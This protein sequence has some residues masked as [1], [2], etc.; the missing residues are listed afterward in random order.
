MA[1]FENILGN[2]LIKQSMAASVALNRVSHAYII[3][4]AAGSGKKLLAYSFA[5]AILCKNKFPSLEGRTPKAEVVCG[6]CRS[7]KTADSGNNPDLVFIA[8]QKA[9]LGIDEVRESIIENLAV[10]PYEADKRVYIINDAHKL[11]PA[12][13]NAMLLTLEDGPEFAVFLLLADSLGNFLPT[14]L[15]RCIQY[16]TRPLDEGVISSYLEGAGLGISRDTAKVAAGFAHGSLGRALALATDE[17]FTAL[18]AMTLD[19]AQRLE[20]MDVAEVFAAAKGLEQHKEQ[21]NDVLDILKMYYR[22]VLVLQENVEK[23][24]NKIHAIDDIKEKL[25]SNCNFLLCMEILLLKCSGA[26]Q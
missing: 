18:R 5:K 10:L 19:L 17:D 16:K 6:V 15:S 2:E 7:C 20:G 3:S 13:Q 11:T 26:P 1:A 23:T 9:S 21:I 4:G 12:A 25:K 24:I 14:M 8:P 22:D